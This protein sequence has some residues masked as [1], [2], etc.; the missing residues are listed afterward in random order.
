MNSNSSTSRTTTRNSQTTRTTRSTSSS[1]SGRSSK[2]STSLDD[3]AK[4]KIGDEKLTM[5]QGEDDES[6][7]GG[8]KKRAKGQ[9]RDPAIDPALQD[10]SE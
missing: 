3:I 8:A 10:D 9:G 7:I 4:E 6:L 1:S 2:S 5:E